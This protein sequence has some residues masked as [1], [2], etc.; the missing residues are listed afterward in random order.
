MMMMMIMMHL[1]ICLSVC[2]SLCPCLYVYL[3]LCRS[4]CL[5][6]VTVSCHDVLHR[7]S[8]SQSVSVCLSD[9]MYV[10][11]CVSVYVGLNVSERSLSALMMRYTDRRGHIRFN[12]FVACFIKLKTMMSK[13]LLNSLLIAQYQPLL[14]K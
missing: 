3:F 5:T 4:E 1:F 7:P 10:Y 8:Q 6:E 13:Q 12:D 11:V 14:K 2:L 9:C